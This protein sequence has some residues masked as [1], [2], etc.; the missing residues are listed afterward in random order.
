MAVEDLWFKKN[1]A[2]TKRSGRGLRWRVRWRGHKSRSFRTKDAA[3][4]HWLKVRTELPAHPSSDSTV[5]DLLE[6]WLQTKR[7][8]TPK[9]YEGCWVGSRHA[10]TQFGAWP[11]G[12]VKRSDVDVWLAGMGKSS[13]LRAKALQALSGAF[14]LAVADGVVPANPCDGAKVKQSSQRVARFLSVAELNRL[15]L[16]AGDSGVL[17][18]MLGTTGLRIGEAVALNVG[19]VDPA[20]RRARVQRSKNGEA[21]DVPVSNSILGR[22]DLDRSRELPLFTSQTGRR[23]DTHN[24]RLRAFRPATES[25]QLPGLHPHDLRH[26]AASL[27]IRSGADVKAVQRMLGHKSAVMTLDL[28]GHLFDKGLDEVSARM[29]ALLAES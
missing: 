9:G 10:M 26:T 20:R 14:R 11:V 7:A 27:A 15:V 1:S 6:R 16:A 17:V 13:A 29:D 23:I 12:E 5:A 8:L 3:D 18:L 24:W 4:R 28:Y 19:D 25:A 22:L 2:P 21:R